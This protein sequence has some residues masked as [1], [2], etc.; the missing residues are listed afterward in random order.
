MTDTS[1]SNNNEECSDLRK[2]T[3]KVIF[4]TSIERVKI[5]KVED[6]YKIF[7]KLMNLEEPFLRNKEDL[8]VLGIDDSGYISCAYII[9]SGIKKIFL[10]TA[11]D[12]FR[13][14]LQVQS[15][16]IV[17]AHNQLAETTPQSEYEDQDYTNKIY[18]QAKSL[19]IELI[20]HIIIN[21][22][23]LVSDEPIYF[24]YKEGRVINA[25]AEDMTYK[26]V[27]EA[28]AVLE[29]ER[30]D[31]L[32]DKKRECIKKGRRIGNKE[33]RRERE[34]EIIRTMLIDDVDINFI[35]KHTDRCLEDIEAI[36]KEIE[37]GE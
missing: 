35:T 30:K 26:T 4:I 3:M 21:N 5:E 36:K 17:I 1:I 18:H 7:V 34:N 23:S 37:M 13:V 2:D 16:K 8:W 20:D 6:Y 32:F 9:E 12:L 14:A 22:E 24:S 19:D 11:M 25:I 28:H 10:S 31:Y 27:A 15:H 33:G 29:I